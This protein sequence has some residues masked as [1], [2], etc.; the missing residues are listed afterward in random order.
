MLNTYNEDVKENN[1]TI[2]FELSI[3]LLDPIPVSQ[4]P[5][6]FPHGL[7]EPIKA[8]LETL[9]KNDFIEASSCYGSP[10]IPVVKKNGDIRI[11]ID[12]RAINKKTIPL[13]F[14]I[15]HPDELIEKV[16]GSAV[17]SVL[18]L[19]QGYFHIPVKKED[20][21]KTAFIVPWGKYQWKRLPLGLLGAP[22]TFGEA[23]PYLFKEMEF[24]VCYFDD[25]LI[26]SKDVNEHFEHLQMAL[27]RLAE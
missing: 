14:P 9:L 1:K 3:D 26:F 16:K 19:K 18:D 15:P 25:I 20:R 12:Y 22:F 4:Q 17:F 21:I 2:P 5:M 10:I 8:Q 7:I 11:A 27:H 6:Q 23:M 24:V 13:R